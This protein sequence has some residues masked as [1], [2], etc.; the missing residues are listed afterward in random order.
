M[1]SL[2]PSLSLKFHK[3]NQ[4]C[5]SG[6]LCTHFPGTQYFLS[7]CSFKSPFYFQ[8]HLLKLSFL[9]FLFFFRDL[10]SFMLRTRWVQIFGILFTASPPQILLNGLS[11]SILSCVLPSQSCPPRT[12]LCFRQCLFFVL[13]PTCLLHLRMVAFFSCTLS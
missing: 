4:E 1:F 2:I 8:K 9:F 11:T 7:M 3:F 5:L 12:L 6:D 10:S 13:L